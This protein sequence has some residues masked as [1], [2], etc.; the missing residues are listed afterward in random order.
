MWA[1]ARSR[2]DVNVLSSVFNLFL[3]ER[4]LYGFVRVCFDVV[5]SH[6]ERH[7]R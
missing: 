4:L 2:T 1:A 6:E 5:D 3:S 7:H